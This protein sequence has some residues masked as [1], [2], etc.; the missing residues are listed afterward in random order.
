MDKSEK[1]KQKNTRPSPKENHR[2]EPMDLN[3]YSL[4]IKPRL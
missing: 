2:L 4:E 3:I 1:G